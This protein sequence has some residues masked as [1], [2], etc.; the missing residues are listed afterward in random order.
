VE[1][2]KLDS[3]RRALE[4][5]LYDKARGARELAGAAKPSASVRLTVGAQE[6]RTATEKLEEL[7]RS[8]DQASAA[9]RPRCCRAKVVR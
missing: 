5:T 3:K 8:R 1:F 7:E 6:L 9:A 2:Q 4:W